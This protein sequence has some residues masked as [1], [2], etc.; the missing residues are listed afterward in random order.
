MSNASDLPVG[1]SDGKKNDGRGKP[2]VATDA[3]LRPIEEHAKTAGIDPAT[4]A[5]VMQSEKWAAG[6]SVP[7]TDFDAAVGKLIG[8]STDTRLRPIEQHAKDAGIDP[9]T[10]AAVMQSEKW[11]AGKSVPKTE[12]KAAVEKFL[13]ASMGGE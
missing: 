12:F 10:L 1:D 13:G 11:A 7:K 8:A 5:A 4:L 9:A 2:P 3:G 6:K